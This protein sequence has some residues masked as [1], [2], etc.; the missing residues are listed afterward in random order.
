M[1]NLTPPPLTAAAAQAP[2]R[3]AGAEPPFRVLALS[4]GGFLGLYSAQVLAALEA[5]LPQPLGRYFDLIAG[6]SVGAI[7]AAAVAREVPMTEIVQLFRNQGRQV[8]SERPLPAGVVGRL[9]DMTRSVLGPKYDG[10]ELRRALAARM[11]SVTMGELKHR[12]VM[13]A[14]NVSHSH[15]KVFKTPHSPLARGDEDIPLL[16]AVMASCAA[17][18]YFPGVRLGT[19]VFADGGLFAVAPDQVALHEAEHFM[20]VSPSRVHMLSVGTATRGYQSAH[21]VDEN[22]GAVGWLADGR[23]ILTLMAVQQQHVVAMMEDRLGERYLR[24]DAPWNIDAGLGLDVATPAA[25]RVL[26]AM[27][28]RTVQEAHEARP[29]AFAQFWPVPEP[30][31][32]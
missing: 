6:T 2:A 23:L 20:G 25:A 3:P 27:G 18:A 26:S 31:L 28:L 13:P 7:L 16:D 21:Q 9:L 1:P 10:Q 5:E 8:F 12:L 22:A 15:T 29:E 11:G 32:A 30:A 4:G 14:V 17:P 24:L 19:D